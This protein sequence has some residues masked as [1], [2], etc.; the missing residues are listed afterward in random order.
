M[1]HPLYALSLLVL[2]LTCSV[3]SAQQVDLVGYW[4][5]DDD[6]G[7]SAVVDE[8]GTSEGIARGTVAFN[9]GG[10]NINSK[11]ALFGGRST[12]IEV[13]HQDSFLLN[14]GTV[15]FWFKTERT[16]G[17]QGILSKD[18]SGN[19]TG[20]HLTMY[21]NGSYLK[22][23]LQ[24]DRTSYEIKSQSRLNAGE[25]YHVAFVF[26]TGGMELYI[27]GVLERTHSYA[28]GFGTNSGGM[29]NY[30]PLVIGSVSWMSGDR[31][32]TPVHNQFYGKIDEVAFLSNRLDS[33]AIADIYAQTGEDGSLSLGD[34]A[35]PPP[36]YYVRKNG[37]DSNDGLSPEK[38]FKTIQH[39]VT[40]CS[41]P[42]VTVYVGPGTYAEEV[43]IGGKDNNIGSVT[44]TQALP[45]SL[46]ADIT[47]EFTGDEPGAV[48]LDGDS[49]KSMGFKIE[50]VE[51]WIIQGFTFVNQTEYAV[52]ALKGGV[53]IL[54][55]TIEVPGKYAFYAQS[56]GSIMIADCSFERAADSGSLVM[57]LPM[58][59]MSSARST[60]TVTRNDMTM[61][62]ELYMSTRYER[63]FRRAAGGQQSRR[64]AFHHGIVILSRPSA[65]IKTVEISNN[66]IS[67]TIFSILS[68]VR[69]REQVTTI[70][71]NNTIVGSYYSVYLWPDRYGRNFVVNNIIDTCYLGVIAFA[72]SGKGKTV[73]AGLLENNITMP[74]SRYRRSFESG[75]I[76]ENPRFVD[77]PAGD[78]SL[79]KGSP[80]IDV[81]VELYAPATDIAGR[82]RPTDGDKD[83]I[84]QIDLGVTELVDIV[85]NRV[86]VVRWR[87]IGGEN[88]R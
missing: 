44:G 38:A 46:I 85:P 73:V 63:G 27:N 8:T 21:L 56:A 6:A 17:T 52:Y 31:V 45:I 84:A 36:V 16:S 82:S 74:M 51:H 37:S 14:E 39:A 71:A 42:G 20:G 50:N 55:C 65:N 41:Q 76:A 26:G 48:I 79:N 80:G 77:A 1:R 75:I 9:E 54:N 7:V 66:Q 34:L 70:I 68:L 72:R 53:S 49:Q 86:R 32:A 33:S 2:F 40:K 15:V 78:F 22:V 3:A 24:S 29:G 5:L 19:D 43:G 23:R 69:Q 18:S 58:G 4:K 30:E 57:I 13:P 61:K 11:A 62:D 12:Y 60:I 10:V 87:E 25:W 28:G 88:N 64:K 35:G 47:G 81:G 67:D 59:N 83:G